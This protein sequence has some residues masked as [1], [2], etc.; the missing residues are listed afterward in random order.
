MHSNMNP[1]L[2]WSTLKAS[3]APLSCPGC[4]VAPA[5]DAVAD[6][7]AGFLQYSSTCYYFAESLTDALREVLL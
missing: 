1:Q 7:K 2:A 5:Q 4:D 3:L 6:E